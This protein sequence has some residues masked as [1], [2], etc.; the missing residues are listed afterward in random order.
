MSEIF[1]P[2]SAAWADV[3]DALANQRAVAF[4]G[5]GASAA[6][7]LPNWQDLL[8]TALAK[9][10]AE[11]GPNAEATKIRQV[12]DQGDLLLGA[13]LLKRS[14]PGFQRYVMEQLSQHSNPS[15]VHR[16][17]ARLSFSQV[18]TTNFDPLLELAYTPPI[19]NRID[20]SESEAILPPLQNNQFCFVKLHGNFS[21][22]MRFVL[23]D[24]DYRDVTYRSH[25][26][27]KC[28]EVLFLTKQV[29]FIGHSLR[30]PDLLGWLSDLKS[31]FRN[32]G[33]HYVIL[34]E[35]D[36]TPS[37]S[38]HLEECFSIKTLTYS[39]NGNQGVALTNVLT[40]VHGC[41]SKKRASRVTG[42]GVAVGRHSTNS[43]I[44][45]VLKQAAHDLGAFRA[46]VCFF[47]DEAYVG[48]DTVGRFPAD[49]LS[50]EESPRLQFDYSFGPPNGVNI[51]ESDSA[52]DGDASWTNRRPSK[53][54]PYS[55]VWS[56][57]HAEARC[58]N[59]GDVTAHIAPSSMPRY[60][61]AHTDVLSELAVPIHRGGLR[62]GVLNVESNLRN[63]FTD[64]HVVAAE[65]FASE[66]GRVSEYLWRSDNYREGVIGTEALDPI[67]GSGDREIRPLTEA[68]RSAAQFGK[69]LECRLYVADYA[70]GQI[71]SKAPTALSYRFQESC[72]ASMV[73]RTG[74]QIY[75]PD[76]WATSSV[77]EFELNSDRADIDG[78]GKQLVGVPMFNRGIT[79][80]VLVSWC[81]LKTSSMESSR[82]E[83]VA[84][85]TQLLGR[86]QYL[87]RI[88]PFRL[89]YGLIC[90]ETV[91]FVKELTKISTL[92]KPSEQLD[93]LIN[94][95]RLSLGIDR[96]RL[97]HNN[98][99][100]MPDVA[101][102]RC[103]SSIQGTYPMRSNPIRRDE[104]VSV[105][106][107]SN[108]KHFNVKNTH[109]N[110]FVKYIVG[111]VAWSPESMLLYPK[112]LDEENSRRDFDSAAGKYARDHS[113]GWYVAPLTVGRQPQA[114]VVT[115][116]IQ[117]R[118]LIGILVADNTRNYDT[119][120]EVITGLDNDLR[121]SRTWHELTR[122]KLNWYANVLSHRM[123]LD[124]NAS[125]NR[126]L[127]G[128]E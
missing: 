50:P 66:I 78:I 42:Q 14:F 106:Y 15:S 82:A 124:L 23:T 17:I 128:K 102:L 56:C 52:F 81:K 51:E 16:A 89:E 2:D 97:F 6:A 40:A 3:I 94:R 123:Y 43:V 67:R 8:D 54:W 110:P 98:R 28:L 5:A 31:E 32:F 19:T 117:P 111:R 119:R 73:F 20:R 49:D 105:K 7:D 29:V 4:V 118:S 100:Q 35:A 108:R 33:N 79:I 83:L 113:V 1:H 114:S 34:S 115:D 55:V 46:D 69:D 77:P 101:N 120:G 75:I 47:H 57:F 11:T 26:L 22:P 76:R 30:D 87:R 37:Y 13:A 88:T 84:R 61:A 95:I 68:V 104:P 122:L 59:I 74:R 116:W 70:A 71:V 80:G 63:A 62:I 9:A 126:G 85:T 44:C 41:V 93:R 39:A 21:N 58:I 103:V 96:V 109:L 18:V 45:R 60:R 92:L 127:A 121:R 48:C 86:A 27:R 25:S 90:E 91:A 64:D 24:A 53:V 36:V 12:L 125:K 107:T 38:Q 65:R 112:L 10:Q 99:W 72:F